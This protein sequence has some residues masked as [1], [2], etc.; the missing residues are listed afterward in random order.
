MLLLIAV[1]VA[2]RRHNNSARSVSITE[3]SC[4]CGLDLET[5]RLRKL[6]ISRCALIGSCVR[7]LL[8]CNWGSFSFSVRCDATI[9]GGGRPGRSGE[10][11]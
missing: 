5:A 10:T 2:F 3:V 11:T 6:L 7:D 8:G 4:R 9:E 1:Q